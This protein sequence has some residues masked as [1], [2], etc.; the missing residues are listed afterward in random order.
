MNSRFSAISAFL[1]ASA[2]CLGSAQAQSSFNAM[3]AIPMGEFSGDANALVGFGASLEHNAPISG[4][5]GWVSSLAFTFNASDKDVPSGADVDISG[6]NYI[7]IPA[8]TGLRL[9]GGNGPVKAYV[10]GQAGILLFL[11]T[12]LTADEA[13]GSSSISTDPNIHFG[14]GGGL[15]LLINDRVNAGVRFFGTPEMDMS[16]HLSSPFFS[17]DLTGHLTVSMVQL[18]VGL[19]F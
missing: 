1:L 7:A 17:D 19:L 12:D 2:L 3:L 16:G 6:G 5:A 13:G 15:G 10:Q 18:N 8:L 4:P 9:T 14:F 11:V